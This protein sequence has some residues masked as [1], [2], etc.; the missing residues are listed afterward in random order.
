M[1]RS[2]FPCI[3]YG[4]CFL[5]RYHITAIKVDTLDTLFFL[6]YASKTLIQGDPSGTKNALFRKCGAAI[7]FE[8]AKF[9]REEVKSGSFG[10]GVSS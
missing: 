5:S 9:D 8:I 4:N 1:E 10:A 3:D 6:N 2:F 7:E